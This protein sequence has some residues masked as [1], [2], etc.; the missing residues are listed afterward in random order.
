MTEGF[1]GLTILF[2]GVAVIFVPIFRM[3]GM[4]SII[5]YL[6]GGIII[7]PYV[8]KL[9][10][11][12]EGEEM[13][14][15]SEFGVVMMLFLI[16]LELDPARLWKMRIPILGLGGLQ[17]LITTIVIWLIS[18]FSFGLSFPVAMSI[19]MIFALSSTA[20]V[21]QLL[22]ETGLKNTFAGQSSFS[23]LLFQDIAVI[24][25]LAILP[26]M[27]G[28]GY[29]LTEQPNLLDKLP[30]YMYTF[31]VIGVVAAIV[32]AGKYLF[33]PFLRMVAKAQ[34]REIFVASSL[35]I[36]VGMSVLMTMINLS[37][38]L[39]AFL[40]GVVLANNEYKHEL[41]SNIE[42]FKGL[43]L[44]VF[45]ISVGASI[46]INFL[47]K[48]PL[49]I[50]SITAGVMVLKAIILLALGK[51]FKMDLDQN[52][53]Y[54]FLLSQMGEFGF[55]LV[56]F[57]IKVNILTSHISNIVMTVIAIS[58]AVTPFVIIL[59]QKVI[60][61]RIGVKERVKKS[62]KQALHEEEAIESGNDVILAGFG[63][64]GAPIGRFLRLHNV[65][66]TILD[67]DSERVKVLREMG[68]K[69]FYGDA[70]RMDLLVAAGA[71][72]AKLLIVALNSTDSTHR[73]V[74][75][76]KKHFPHLDILVRTEDHYD[77]FDILEEGIPLSRIFRETLDS[78][79][80]MSEKALTLLGVDPYGAHRSALI[81]R[82][83]EDKLM[84]ELAQH[85]HNKKDYILAVREKLEDMEEIMKS[86]LKYKLRSFSE[87]WS[88]E[89]IK[90]VLEEQI[91]EQEQKGET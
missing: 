35:L 85:R 30:V 65:G 7:G 63:R 69:V 78:S 41:E 74:K 28:S 44:G 66:C 27:G 48:E 67:H 49:M 23:V 86:D 62:K 89:L 8:L 17:V 51:A 56:A 12:S 34:L 47:L 29:E 15:F 61:P 33:T 2:L 1:W 43:L 36:V 79:I 72:K 59:T 25:M 32:L 45:F 60:L 77:T 52:I 14:H 11:V 75:V 26:L 55:V 80:K 10:G 90:K 9:V 82:K 21:L 31:V 46:N 54:T 58:M 37:P 76:A 6:I 19:G 4:S 5:G 91:E 24:P 3:L 38:A 16:G 39:G 22:S 13:L 81:F 87:P 40:A 57:A 53:I 70:S 88:S 83:Q 20:I 71:E 68:F 42:P 84:R 64:F 50:L 18:T 73:L